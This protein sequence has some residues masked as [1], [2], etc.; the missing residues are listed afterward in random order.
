MGFS[1]VAI[2]AMFL[3]NLFSNMTTG[4]AVFENGEENASWFIAIGFL[5]FGIIALFI[6]RR[7]KSGEKKVEVEKFDGSIK[8]VVPVIIDKK[9]KEEHYSK[10]I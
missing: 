6:Q 2:G 9:S 4:Y 8:D 10:E 1:L 3:L 7:M 5:V